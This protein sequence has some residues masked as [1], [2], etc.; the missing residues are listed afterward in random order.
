MLREYKLKDI[1]QGS[2][3]KGVDIIG[4]LTQVIKERGITAG[5][6]SG[7]GAVTEAHIGYFNAQTKEYEEGHFRE[8]MEILSLRGNVSIKDGDVFPHL[9]AVLSKRDFSAVGGHLY[10]G[11]T[12]Y[13][14]EFEIIS[15]DGEPFVRQFDNNTGLHLWKE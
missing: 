9:H 5:I 14:F 7:I 12:V 13:A 10:A 15:M 4:G 6:V 1:Y 8:N 3:K 2:L 11:T